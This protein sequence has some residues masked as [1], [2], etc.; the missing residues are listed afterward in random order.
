MWRGF[1]WIKKKKL[2]CNYSY[3]GGFRMDSK[4]LSSHTITIKNPHSS[5]TVKNVEIVHKELPDF[6][7][8]YPPNLDYLTENKD[9]KIS[10]I[11]F[12]EIRADYQ[13]SIH[14]IYPSSIRYI[15]ILDHIFADNKDRIAISHVM[16]A[17]LVTN[18][19]GIDNTN[20]HIEDLATIH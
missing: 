4:E 11:I 17:P 1:W 5:K 12:P 7:D 8:I 19:I 15:D 14:Y 10:K 20:S 6:V 9:G 13:I 18:N 16:M 2:E 3:V